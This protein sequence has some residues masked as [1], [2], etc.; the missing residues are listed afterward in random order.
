MTTVLVLLSVLNL[1][2]FI[3]SDPF[4]GWSFSMKFNL[5]KTEAIICPVNGYWNSKVSCKTGNNNTYTFIKRA[6]LKNKRS[7]YSRFIE[8]WKS[9]DTRR[10]HGVIICLFPDEKQLLFVC[11]LILKSACHLWEG[12]KQYIWWSF[13]SWFLF[14]ASKYVQKC[15]TRNSNFHLFNFKFIC[16]MFPP[17]WENFFTALSTNLLAQ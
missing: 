17:P 7:S 13:H 12:F 14:F 8:K 3:S 15:K 10:L 1:T 4:L 5:A 9:H 11:W 6:N 2:S 16:W